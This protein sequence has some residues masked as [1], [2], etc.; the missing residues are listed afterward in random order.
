ME[1]ELMLLLPPCSDVTSVQLK[2]ENGGLPAALVGRGTACP[3]QLSSRIGG[4]LW[5]SCAPD[6]R[7]TLYLTLPAC[8]EWHPTVLALPGGAPAVD[9]SICLEVLPADEAVLLLCTTN[10]LAS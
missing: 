2:K 9:S 6:S 10:S 7:S 3:Q 5:R 8:T 4:C 1:A